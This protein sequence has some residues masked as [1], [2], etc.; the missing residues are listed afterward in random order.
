MGL[1]IRSVVS[2]TVGVV[3][4]PRRS[5]AEIPDALTDSTLPWTIASVAV[6]AA[7]FVG[8]MYHRLHQ[9]LEYGIA[10][11][12]GVL[13]ELRDRI[14]DQTEAL[15]HATEQLEAQRQTI[16]ELRLT[17][18]VTGLWTRQHV[19]R[20]LATHGARALRTWVAW[21][22]GVTK[23]K[24]ENADLLIF[25]VGLDKLEEATV[26]LGNEV[27]AGVLS[28]FADVLRASSRS[29]DVLARWGEREF[30]VVRSGADR[31]SERELAERLRESV[32]SHVFRPSGDLE[33]STTCSIGFAGHPLLTHAPDAL[34]W[35]EV[36]ALAE[37]ALGAA[38]RT[39]RNSWVGLV[40]DASTPSEGLPE[41]L[42]D[43]PA[44]LIAKE[45]LRVVTSFDDV[46]TVQWDGE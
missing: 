26:A 9:R 8:W 24:P 37:A 12:E 27:V 5:W 38:R 1:R 39:G 16:E 33:L 3:C 20:V 17:D 6:V 22:N 30:M 23:N 32:A 28:E 18:A 31:S 41:L 19:F 21:N 29:T 43:G 13:T 45:R 14:G 36:V 40:G 10:E 7:V 15:E 11:M 4:V 2:W 34:G 46:T 25:I 44:A 42:I 35:E